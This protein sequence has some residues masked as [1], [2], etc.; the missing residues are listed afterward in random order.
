V[1]A[2]AP[3]L[4]RQHERH[5]LARRLAPSR[6]KEGASRRQLE[7]GRAALARSVWRWAVVTLH[8][9]NG[10]AG[11]ARCPPFPG[12]APG[13]KRLPPQALRAGDTPCA[14]RAG[15]GSGPARSARRGRGAG[16][17]VP[18]SGY[19]GGVTP[20]LGGVATIYGCNSPQRGCNSPQ[21]GVHAP[22]SAGHRRAPGNSRP[23]IRP[24]PRRW[25]ASGASH[26]S[27]SRT[28][29]PHGGDGGSAGANAHVGDGVGTGARSRE[30]SRRSGGGAPP[31]PWSWW[32]RGGAPVR[33]PGCRP[34]TSRRRPPATGG[35]SGR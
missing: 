29:V 13:R 16:E 25:P 8:A 10:K 14:T 15:G 7:R 35:R 32:G 30:G 27:H 31:P 6:R 24:A 3:R 5:D 17:Y 2:D 1:P 9:C 26:P 19:L 28:G 23:A 20:T 21:P 18:H 11:G 22:P 4:Q 34:I 33:R 12:L